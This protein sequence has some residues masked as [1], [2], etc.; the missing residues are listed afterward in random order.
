MALDIDVLNTKLNQLKNA[1]NQLESLINAKGL[2][3]RYAGQVLVTLTPQQEAAI[4]ASIISLITIMAAKM[5]EVVD[6]ANA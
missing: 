1:T 3:L 2:T 6:A 5:Q 4:D